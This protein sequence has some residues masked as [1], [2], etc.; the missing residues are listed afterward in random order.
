M[1]G[2]MT[3]KRVTTTIDPSTYKKM[4]LNDVRLTDALE[5]GAKILCGMDLEEEKLMEKE[6]ET[7]NKL[8]YIKKRLEELRKEKEREEKVEEK[9]SPEGLFEQDKK[10]I[11]EHSLDD[12]PHAYKNLESRD[13]TPEVYKKIRKKLKKKEGV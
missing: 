8:K 10:F 11:R 7:K 6:E 2:T 4:V 1:T 9:A 3:K 13:V 5:T 12:Y